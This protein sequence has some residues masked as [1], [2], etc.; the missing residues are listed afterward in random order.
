MLATESHENTYTVTDDGGTKNP[1]F[2][3]AVNLKSYHYN[4]VKNTTLKTIRFEISFDMWK[5][6]D[7]YQHIYLRND[8]VDTTGKS[9][10][11]IISESLVLSQKLDISSGTHHKSYTVTLDLEKF[12]NSN[13]FTLLFDA[14]G[15]FSDTWKFNN[16]NIK[17][18]LT[19]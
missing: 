2:Q 10:M 14:S 6:D 15:A 16:L 3:I 1:N 18:Y 4:I 12:R 5:V 7:G 8:D 13:S 11:E 19:N 17:A 9:P